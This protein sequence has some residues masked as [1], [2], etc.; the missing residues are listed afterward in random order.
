MTPKEASGLVEGVTLG[1]SVNDARIPVLK[2]SFLLPEY[3]GIG[4]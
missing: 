2:A 4:R 3:L 1:S